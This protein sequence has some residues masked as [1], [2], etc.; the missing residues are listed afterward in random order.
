MIEKDFTEIIQIF[1]FGALRAPEKH[2][3]KGFEKD[4]H[5][6]FHVVILISKTPITANNLALSVAI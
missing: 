5:V 6:L 1:L 4:T 2:V 3:L